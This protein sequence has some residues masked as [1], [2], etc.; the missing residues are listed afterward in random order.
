MGSCRLGVKPVSQTDK[1]TERAFGSGT[2]IG[3]TET[4]LAMVVWVEQIFFR[5]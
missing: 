4:A 1:I 5:I 3:V 2:A